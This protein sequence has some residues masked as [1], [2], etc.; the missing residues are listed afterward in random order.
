MSGEALPPGIEEGR[1]ASPQDIE[2]LPSITREAVHVLERCM[3][4]HHVA[5]VDY[6]EP[7]ER[8]AT[9]RFRPAFI[10]YSKAHN[11]VAWGLPVGTDH[12]VELRL[13]RIR[14]VRDTGKMFQPS[15]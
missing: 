6:T 8:R 3:A 15:W 13:D 4:E 12:W 10:R 14:E 1:E 7:D 2:S 11:L 5:E 9:I